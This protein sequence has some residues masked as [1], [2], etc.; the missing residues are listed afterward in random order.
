MVYLKSGSPAMT[1]RETDNV[2]GQN[3]VECTWFEGNKKFEGEFQEEQ[4]TKQDPK[5]IPPTSAINMG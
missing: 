2:D 1:V 4:L 3:L 5:T